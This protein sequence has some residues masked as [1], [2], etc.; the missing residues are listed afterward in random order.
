MWIGKLLGK[1]KNV[2]RCGRTGEA[3]AAASAGK[4]GAVSGNTFLDSLD[5]LS[6]DDIAPEVKKK[7]TP[8]E[9]V[10]SL[11]RPAAMVIFG[12]VF[13]VSAA[14]FIGRLADY[15]RAEDLYTEIADN[16]F[17]SDMSGYHA[18]AY[19]TPDR[20]MAP[21]SDYYTALSADDAPGSVQTGTRNEKF[22]AVKAN[23]EYMRSI[24]PDIYGYIHI[25]GTK[26]SFP[27]V[28][29]EDNEY[30]L[31]RAWNGE[32]LVV[33][34]IF[35]DCRADKDVENNY[36]TVLYG[37]NMMDGNMFNNVMLFKDEEIFREKL[38]EVYTFDGVYTY[39]PFSIFQTVYTY[40]YFTMDFESGEDFVEF[41]EEMQANSLHSKDMEFTENDRIITLSTCTPY[42]DPSSY[43]VG[44]YALHA[45]LVKV[46]K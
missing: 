32:F 11:V 13:V 6:A 3:D 41:C 29:G 20:Q 33:G 27:I 37:H 36:N 46:E 34:S 18:V 39:E 5:L 25:D 40:Q 16:I 9:V 15:K 2:F 45:K 31:E 35:A 43:Y 42:D 1:I 14:S 44:R 28:Q 8:G 4:S 30:Y 23:L 12:A 26:I 22:E 21:L 19:C 24:N 7:R 10:R 38:I 17:N